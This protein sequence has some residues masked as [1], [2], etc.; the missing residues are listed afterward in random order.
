[1]T[2]AG[3]LGTAAWGCAAADA[4]SP[5]C[6]RP[7]AGS[8]GSADGEPAFLL[9]ALAP[10]GAHGLD[11]CF[12]NAP[13]WQPYHPSLTLHPKQ[14]SPPHQPSKPDCSASRPGSVGLKRISG[15]NQ[16]CC[17]QSVDYSDHPWSFSRYRDS[18]P[19]TPPRD[20]PGGC[21]RAALLKLHTWSL[22]NM[23]LLIQ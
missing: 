23:Q 19:R 3:R 18:L 15:T 5:A 13:Q 21:I 20:A 14:P 11:V 1:M 12:W 2:G 17:S 6:S 10:L 7:L 16:S 9:A 22:V 4:A 8:R